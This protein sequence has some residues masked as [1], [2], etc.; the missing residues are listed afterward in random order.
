LFAVESYVELTLRILAVG[1]VDAVSRG[2][3]GLLLAI[4]LVLGGR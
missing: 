2:R 1:L 3:R 4:A